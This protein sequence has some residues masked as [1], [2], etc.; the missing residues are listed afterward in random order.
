MCACARV[1]K[2]KTV[3]PS[4]FATF[5]S[6]SLYDIFVPEERYK[7]Q[8]AKL[9]ASAR[10]LETTSG[11]GRVHREAAQVRSQAGDHGQGRAVGRAVGK[12]GRRAKLGGRV[13][14]RL[15]DS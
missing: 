12:A 3:S 5:W 14:T 4:Y 1:R 15:R 2:Q 10:E 13:A 6:L 11:Q 9:R 8:A 7:A